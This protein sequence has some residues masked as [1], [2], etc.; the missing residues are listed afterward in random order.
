[1]LNNGWPS[2]FWHLYDWYLQPAGGYYGAKKGCEPLHVQYD[3]ADRGV[4]VVNGLPK[5]FGGL[6]VEAAVY[7]FDLRELFE[8]SAQVDVE[9]DGRALALTLPPPAASA[10]ASF[11]KLALRDASGETVSTNFYWL[12]PTPT[13]FD[14]EKT[15]STYTPATRY[16]DL[17]A[18]ERLPRVRLEASASVAG[19]VV[20]VR[21]RNAT[22]SLA[23]QVRLGLHGN[24]AEAD[25]GDEV[26]PA[27]WSDNYVALMPG[28]SRTLTVRAPRPGALDG[29]P[30]VVVSGWNVEAA[31]VDTT[32]A[33]GGSRAARPSGAAPRP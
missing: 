15:D 32:G 18:L 12:P 8:K 5:R 14:W 10:A 29:K 13:T 33:S 20:T 4:Q 11:V 28:E 2:L 17:T 22:T 31:R 9:A 25:A 30:V 21:L 1:M 24:A 6:T 27:F 23:F 7:D 16:E 26:V 3:Y 19:D